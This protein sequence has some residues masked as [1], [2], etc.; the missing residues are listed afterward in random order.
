MPS[1]L[2]L[3]APAILA[4]TCLSP[5][6]ATAAPGDLLAPT[7]AIPVTVKP[8][9]FF[10]GAG[11]IAT[12]MRRPAVTPVATEGV[13]SATDTPVMDFPVASGQTTAGDHAHDVVATTGICSAYFDQS[14]ALVPNLSLAFKGMAGDKT[15]L[16]ALLPAL[17]KQLDGL[18]PYE[19]KPEV[20]GGD[21]INAYTTYQ[22]SELTIL[23]AHNVD[24]GLPA[25]L[26]IVKQPDLTLGA[27]AYA[28]GWIRFE[29][30]DYEGALSAFG[31]GLAMFPHDHTLQS[32]YIG[33]LL[34]LKRASQ[35]VSFI[36]TVLSDTTDLDDETRSKMFAGRGIGFV[37]QG[38][39]DPAID[40]MTVALRYQYS[41]E[42]KNM[43][44][45][46]VALKAS[47]KK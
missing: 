25:N 20:C 39:L 5:L 13:P 31:K 2:R 14:I 1:F 9:S 24:I 38:A 18:M 32:E 33:T 37:M 19:I 8:H 16:P 7:T 43:L 6:S 41:D 17:S 28:V 4:F 36:D 26:P 40:S 3:A 27:L 47:V 34:Q 42:V 21:H 29:Q 23:R 15:T 22:F 30:Q 12:L 46:L 45:Q 10:L 35:A 11:T 44:D